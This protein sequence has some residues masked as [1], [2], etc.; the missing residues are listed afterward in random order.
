MKKLFLY[1]Y[2]SLA[3]HVAMAQT[4]D[5]KF[6]GSVSTDKIFLYQYPDIMGYDSQGMKIDSAEI[7]NGQFHFDFK[8]GPL[9]RYAKLIQMKEKEGGK[10]KIYYGETRFFLTND[11]IIILTGDSLKN[12]RIFNSPV[13]YEYVVLQEMV[14]PATQKIIANERSIREEAMM[15]PQAI[16]ESRDYQKFNRM[17]QQQ[18]EKERMAAYE[19]FIQ[20]YPYSWISL[21]ALRLR[22]GQGG[23]NIISP[24]VVRLYNGLGKMLKQSEPGSAIGKRIAAKSRVQIGAKAP[25]F[26]L[27]DTS[28]R[29]VSLADYRGKYVLL[30][31]WSTNCGGCRAEA[32]H[33]KS[34]FE[35][36]HK[37]GFD[38]LSVSL[39]DERYKYSG[40]KEWL[41]AIREDGTGKWR[42][43]SDLKGWK[44]APALLYDIESIPQNYLID[45]DGK[46]ISENLR[47]ADLHGKL[48]DLF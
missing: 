29:A 46:I 9:P 41:E 33:L 6:E 22:L 35:K 12:V 45:P 2:A 32:P 26:Q 39:N 21:Y 47:G 43:V 20:N 4:I 24:E 48:A 8:P 5:G 36:Y 7:V 38:I 28:G 30:E 14:Q 40:R 34:A 1:L 15:V 10:G 18:A 11:S 25:V 16:R 27:N 17:R 31:F 37:K 3:M 13:N 19:Y 23:Q 42:H 44:S